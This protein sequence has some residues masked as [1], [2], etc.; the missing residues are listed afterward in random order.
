MVSQKGSPCLFA[1]CGKGNFYE[2]DKCFHI[3]SLGAVS[4]AGTG[5]AVSDRTDSGDRINA[6]SHAYPRA[7]VR[8]FLWLALGNGSGTDGS[9]ASVGDVR[10][11]AHVPHGGMY[12]P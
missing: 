12:E 11:A 7:A 2:K 10:N 8:L 3:G 5:A 9:V 4:G 6:L 1:F